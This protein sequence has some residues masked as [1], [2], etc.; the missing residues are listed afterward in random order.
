MRTRSLF[1][2]LVGLV[3][4]LAVSPISAQFTTYENEWIN[5][6]VRH[7]KF[8]VDENTLC[9]IDY[10]TLVNA[11]IPLQGSSMRIYSRGQEIP[12][13]V[14]TNGT[15]GAN[16]FIEFVAKRNDGY[17][18]TQLY[19][20]EDHQAH[21]ARSMFSDETAFYLTNDGST[22]ANHYQ[23]I[24]NDLSNIPNP[25]PNF[26]HTVKT[27]YNE[28]FFQG[29]PNH[30]LGNVNNYTGDWEEGEGIV[31]T[32]YPAF[33]I[34]DPANYPLEGFTE[35][36]SAD[37]PYVDYQSTNGASCE[38]K[39]I[40]RSNDF[41]LFPDHH[42][43]LHVNTTEYVED[44]FEGYATNTYNFNFPVNNLSPTTD[45][46]LEGIYDVNNADKIPSFSIAYFNFTYPRL[47]NFDNERNFHFT[48]NNDGN[49]YLEI[50]NFDGGTQAVLYDI[51]NS[52][53]YSP[54]LE[55]GKYKVYIPQ[56]GSSP[57]REFFI[58][59]TTNINAVNEIET[60]QERDFIDFSSAQNQGDFVILS[61][62]FLRQG[63]T[64]YVQAYAD[65]RASAAG[66]SHEVLLVE[67]EELY[68]Q[69]GHGIKQ[70]P[71]SIRN[72]SNY[73][74]DRFQEGDWSVYPEHML[75]LGRSFAYSKAFLDPSSADLNLV[76]TYGHKGSDIVL[77][78]RTANDYRYQIAVG[79]VSA[80][81][82]E[83]V[84]AYL[85]KV[86]EYEEAQANIGCDKESRL[87]QK[88]LIHIGGGNNQIEA[89][90][91]A[92][93]LD[94]L[95]RITEDTLTGNKVVIDFSKG[96]PQI[97][98]LPEEVG[99]HIEDGIRVLT[100]F[101]HANATSWEFDLL[102]PVFYNNQGKYP[103]FISMSCFV[104]NVHQ[105]TE[106]LPFEWIMTPDRGAIGFL[107]TVG[108][109]FPYYLDIYQKNFYKNFSADNYGQSIGQCM[110]ATTDDVYN[111][112]NFGIK[113][114][115]HE[116][117]L[118]GD[119]AIKMFSM[120]N[121]EYIIEEEDVY[122]EPE[123]IS[124]A[125]EYFDLNV[126]ITNAGKAIYDSLDL[127]VERRLPNGVVEV[128][129]NT[130]IPAPLY[131][132]TVQ[133]TLQNDATSNFGIN[134]FEIKLDP[135]NLIEED[136]ESN[137]S[138]TRQL[139]IQP[140]SALP[141]EPCDFAIV[142]TQDITLYA[143]TA[144]P[145]LDSPKSFVFQ[146]DTDKDFDGPDMQETTITQLGGVLKWKPNVNYENDKVYFWRVGNV[147]TGDENPSWQSSSF[148]Y[149]ENGLSGWSQSHPD[150]LA[151]NIYGDGMSIADN[152]IIEFGPFTNTVS[153]VTGWAP[154]SSNFT[155][156]DIGYSLNSTPVVSESCLKLSNDPCS[157]GIAFA[158]FKP[159][160]ILEP[161]TSVKQG[162][163]VE[164][165]K[166][167]GQYGNNHCGGN[168]VGHEI[169]IFE[170]F[171]GN[172]EY[173]SPGDPNA[174]EE[175]HK[176]GLIEDFLNDI[177]VGHYI[178]AYSIL[179]HRIGFNPDF[180]PA[181]Q[182]VI[183]ILEDMGATGLGDIGEL[184]QGNQFYDTPFIFF[185][186]K[187]F[188]DYE[189]T[190]IVSDDLEQPLPLDIEVDGKNSAGSYDTPLIGPSKSWSHMEYFQSSIDNPVLDE[191]FTV[192]VFGYDENLN[193]TYL[194]NTGMNPFV[195]FNFITAE[196]YPFLKLRAINKDSINFTPP[197]LDKW[198]VYYDK[199]PEL[200]LDQASYYNWSADTLR[201]GDPLQFGIGLTS[202]NDNMA[203]NFDIDFSLVN[204]QNESIT[205]EFPDQTI[206]GA[207][208]TSSIDFTL[209]TDGLIGQ[210]FLEVYINPDGEQCEKFNF[211]N[212]LLLP[213]FVLNDNVNPLVDVTFDGIH[214]LSGDI[215][216]ASPNINV[217]IKDEN[218]ETALSDTTIADVFLTYPS[219]LERRV[220]YADI[221]FSP[222]LSSDLPDKNEAHLSIAND[223]TEAGIYQL[224]V[225]G[226]DMNGNES[227]KFDY[228][229]QFEVILES[230]VSNLLNYPN[231]FTTSTQFVFT[232]TGK[233][234]PEV[235]KI[236]VMNIS[237][238]VV[239]EIDKNELGN[240]HIGRNISDY[241]WDGH[242]TYGNELGNGVYFYRVIVSD[243]DGTEWDRYANVNTQN[244]DKLFGDY[245]IGKM[246]K[247]R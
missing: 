108:F 155:F 21:Y 119:P 84:S 176:W 104:G 244:M 85:N 31:S 142:N 218:Q 82:P 150:Q 55:D 72:F 61:H 17:F 10:Q 146:I 229:T 190:F 208:E 178:L 158:V 3:S 109:G 7:Y 222:A 225:K 86:I 159:E 214:I 4:I 118:Q 147:V 141:L 71:I 30:S 12:I 232:L 182:N 75:L 18:D 98:P 180:Q 133:L 183:D 160:K 39:I 129:L 185:G 156:S 28:A 63:E 65:Y 154:L 79:R 236:Q 188:P 41:A 6:D 60:L 1:T 111:P 16:D 87:W 224:K 164:D 127:I 226:R 239:R 20:E 120:P 35:T 54:T 102:P 64:D 92:N 204:N 167:E 166:E 69:F 136:C 19:L 89:D 220:K 184:Q 44:E 46:T 96:Q 45:F 99:D 235:F 228:D 197:Q 152:G 209:P 242:D 27:T 216:S 219:G 101:G 191:S 189:S 243:Q 213:F 157:G 132:D 103:L 231:P 117:L 130:R 238:K 23:V 29:F 66:G 90:T 170:F 112:T 200:A 48:L 173:F 43:K 115:C 230:S 91:I 245:G 202:V 135:Q 153:A 194:F 192:D 246:Y 171:T 37:L 207:G 233:E 163:W 143:S 128:A 144:S 40:G 59:T 205:Q 58:S 15:F 126:A 93:S 203:S 76:P 196:D 116:F 234:L 36:R 187:G 81:N 161:L 51:T 83:D 88:H 34:D 137:N 149:V 53:R 151:E 110:R 221:E 50:E 237:G 186:R 105:D 14:S 195:E 177:P 80:R 138:I 131:R 5:Y 62:P 32:I 168:G 174:P 33:L 215:V 206:L 68:D 247:V 74:V 106:T 210:N 13:Y 77:T 25:E 38:A 57:T 49:K 9:R 223:F 201:A 240:L 172:I 139:F 217:K 165:C 211:N 114:T 24:P 198:D 134:E 52:R 94:R 175:G 100:F 124:E 122:F 26:Q 95:K 107:A 123:I 67:M 11:G 47:F 70:H 145:L 2:L 121:P 212:F 8:K 241:R 97:I 113:V 125:V 140:A 181:Q 73:I 193:E 56:L 148:T 169:E 179:E 227:G 42:L 162:L 199:A 78:S 22:S